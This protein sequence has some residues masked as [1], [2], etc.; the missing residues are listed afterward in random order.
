M[1]EKTRFD[2]LS[3]AEPIYFLNLKPTLNAG[4]DTA[5]IEC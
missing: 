4:T 1:Q 5:A 2:V 3:F